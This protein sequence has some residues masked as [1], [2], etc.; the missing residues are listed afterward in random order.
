MYLSFRNVSMLY[1]T[2]SCYCNGFWCVFIAQKSLNGRVPGQIK[3]VD[4]ESKRYERATLVL[5]DHCACPV[6]SPHPANLHKRSA[7]LCLRTN[8]CNAQCTSY[9][10]GRI[11]NAP[12]Y[13][14]IQ[15]EDCLRALPCA[16]LTLPCAILT[17]RFRSCVCTNPWG[18]WPLILRA[19]PENS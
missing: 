18:I 19:A 5:A 8:C 3:H 6:P 7:K 15:A 4:S 10:F 13:L 1:P 16:I 17:S 2:P 11:M 12:F 14:H 9:I